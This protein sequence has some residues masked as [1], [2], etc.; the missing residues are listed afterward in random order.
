MA[1][2][3]DFLKRIRLVRRPS[4]AMGKTVVAITA[5]LCILALGTLGISVTRLRA[6]TEALRARAT[7]LE[8]ENRIM[9]QRIENA[10]SVQGVRDIAEAELDLADPDSVIFLPGS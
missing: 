9:E 2:L 5:V 10:D 3:N 1:E 4:T 8:Q 7:A 6:R